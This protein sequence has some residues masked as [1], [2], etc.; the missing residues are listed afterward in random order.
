MRGRR[1]GVDV[2]A[3]AVKG[4]VVDLT[5]GGRAAWT[6]RETPPAR[7]PHA[8]AD[9]IADMARQ[10]DCSGSVGIALPCTVLDGVAV[11]AENIDEEWIGTDAV[12]LF[13]KALGGRTVTVLND[14]D[15][16]GIA[17]ARHGAA[18]HPGTVLVL[19]FGTGIGSA[20]LR[21]G[22]LVPNTEYGQMLVD[23]RIAESYVSAAVREREQLSWPE[24]IRRANRFL[25]VAEVVVS[26]DRIVIGGGIT[27][28]TFVWQDRLAT[29]TP[30]V[31]ALL[32]NDAGI[33]GAAMTAAEVEEHERWR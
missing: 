2:G 24:W 14:A 3:S 5:D 27:H 11:T 13:E 26:L 4:A 28:Y 22:E 25:Q 8:I 29:R 21:G 32:R 10:W 30:V 20:V 23:G 31:P 16:A 1:I 9:C 6:V 33:V 15:A 17:E 7:T 12:E 19:T 18:R